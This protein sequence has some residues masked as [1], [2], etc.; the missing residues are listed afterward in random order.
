MSFDAPAPSAARARRAENG[1]EIFHRVALHA[2]ALRRVA[3][4]GI[5]DDAQYVFELHDR[6]RRQVALLAE[7]RLEQVVRELPLRVGHGANREAVARE[8]FGR[9]KPPVLA[10]PGVEREGGL[11]LLLGS[12]RGQKPRGGIGHGRG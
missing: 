7:P 9:H 1:D 8:H 10:L 12:Q 11:L 6:G 2:A 3:A 4:A 5:F